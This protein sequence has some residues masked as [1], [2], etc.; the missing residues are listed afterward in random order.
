[1]NLFNNFHAQSIGIGALGTTLLGVVP[2]QSEDL[3]HVGIAVITGII[4]IIHLLK[5]NKRKKQQNQN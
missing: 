2:G 5:N 1:M 4:Q 3:V